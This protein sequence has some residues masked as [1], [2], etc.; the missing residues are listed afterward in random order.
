MSPA[1]GL[2][3]REMEVTMSIKMSRVVGGGRYATGKSVCIA[4][5]EFWDGHSWQSQ[6][7]NTFLYRSPRGRFFVVNTTCWQGECDTLEPL[8]E[9]EAVELYENLPEQH[10][11]YEDAF[12]GRTVE[13]A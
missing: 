10:V 5:D 7:R 3:G 6:G 8:S 4:D 13:E 12:P 9:E 2:V 11:A 1:V